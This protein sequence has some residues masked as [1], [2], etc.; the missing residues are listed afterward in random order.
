MNYVI[1][2][3]SI[4]LFLLRKWCALTLF[5]E[6]KKIVMRITCHA[7]IDFFSEKRANGCGKRQGN[8][9]YAQINSETRALGLN[10]MVSPWKHFVDCIIC[11]YKK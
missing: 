7:F 5:K 3:A 11:C 2:A 8:F 9:Q 4:F 1:V 10:K 6:N